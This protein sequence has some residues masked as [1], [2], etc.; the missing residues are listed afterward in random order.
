MDKRGS[1]KIL[2]RKFF[3]SQFRKISYRNPSLLCFRSFLVAKKFFDKRGGGYQDCASKYFCLIVTKNSIG[4]PVNIS[5]ISGIEKVW[6]RGWGVLG[7][8]NFRRR[9]PVSQCRKN[10]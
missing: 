2:S 7:V 1:I 9:L 6:M 5:L 3:V 4:E 10:S 8:K